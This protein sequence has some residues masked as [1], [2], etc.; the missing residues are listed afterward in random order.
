MNLKK[1]K[2]SDLFFIGLLLVF[3]Y[4][5]WRHLP[6]MVIRGDGFVYMVSSTLNEFFN[7]KYF[8]T[9]FELSAELLGTLLPKIF[10]TNISF[11]FYTSLSVMMFINILFYI[12]LRVIVKRKFISFLGALLFAVN[13]FGNF[14]MYSQHCYCFFMER[15]IPM[16]FM[17]PA[18]LYLHLFLEKQK[19]KYYL[20]SLLLYFLGIG[21]GHF[22]LLFTAPYLFYPFFWHIFTKKIDKKSLIKGIAISISFLT[23]SIFFVL[24]Q[25]ISYSQIGPQKGIIQ[26]FLSF[27]ENNY[28]E[29]ILRQLSYWSQYGSVIRSFDPSSSYRSLDIKSASE[30]TVYVAI[31]YCIV[32]LVIYKKLPKMRYMLFTV[33]FSIIV[34]FY[35]NAWFGQYDVLYQP[36]ANRYLYF[37]TILLVM[38]WTLFLWVLLQWKNGLIK[39]FAVLLFFMY[40]L[41][42][43]L[44]ISSAFKDV[45][46]WDRSTKVT[47]NYMT[48]MREGLKKGTLVVAPYPEVGVYE[49][50]FFTEQLGNKEVEFL[51]EY[52]PYRDWNNVATLSAAV[53]RL[54]YY[55]KCDCIKEQKIK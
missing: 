45:L 35:L 5:P 50:Q 26:Y 3:A 48:S 13:Y 1:V 32:A 39:L 42:N 44:L 10:K 24:I 51:A 18:F 16:I 33:I 20:I 7:R 54:H 27:Q 15:I 23:I 2:L 43:W 17:I 30:N 29:K 40:Y 52:H 8:Y 6:E 41:L 11:Y 19:S 34:I 47:Y 9:G 53:I 46:S 28:T 14:D 21:I 4:I 22:S 31:L 55:K 36:D 38:F 37:P 25:K 49:S 12:L